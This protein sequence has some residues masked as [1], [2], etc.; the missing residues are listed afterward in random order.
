MIWVSG[1]SIWDCDDE[2]KK[3]VKTFS[4][5]LLGANCM[6]LSSCCVFTMEIESQPAA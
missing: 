1:I 6:T 5:P 4:L 2:S 3:H